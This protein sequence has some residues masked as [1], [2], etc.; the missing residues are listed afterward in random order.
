MGRS[1]FQPETLAATL[2]VLAEHPDADLV[3]GGTDLVVGDRQGKRPLGD[4]LV[5]IHALDELRGIE[6]TGAGGLRL[7]GLAT[8][9]EIEHHDVIR[10]RF[11]TLS[12]G[13]ALVGSPATRMSG[14]IGGNVPAWSAA[15]AVARRRRRSNRPAVATIGASRTTLD[16]LMTT[17]ALSATAPAVWDA[18]TT[19]PTS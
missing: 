9:W 6:E 15:A 1:Y 10:S 8:H 16:N 18:A 4:T 11:S 3:A 12:D 14:T 2:D 17:A 7:G 19:C 13:S 5:A